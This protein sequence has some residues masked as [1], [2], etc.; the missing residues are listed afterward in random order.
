MKLFASILSNLTT[1][2][3]GMESVWNVR[4]EED[5][6]AP[7]QGTIVAPANRFSDCGLVPSFLNG[8]I[9]GG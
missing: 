1:L 3:K 4:G 8:D 2:H 5:Y 6:Y 9:I 7:K